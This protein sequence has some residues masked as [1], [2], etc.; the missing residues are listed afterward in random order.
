MQQTTITELRARRIWDSRGRPTIEAQ[1]QLADGSLGLGQAP[2]GASTGRHEALELRDG[3]DDPFL[4]GLDVQTAIRQCDALI[5]PMLIG[6][7][8]DQQ[9]QIDQ[10]LIDIDPHPNKAKLGANTTLAVSL[11]CAKAA[12]QSKAVALYEHLA[13]QLPAAQSEQA[14]KAGWRLPLPQIQIFG[15]G[16]HAAKRID[17]QDLMVTCPAA[18]TVGEALTW[19]A[20]VYRAA[21]EVMRKRRASYG[22]ADEGG[23]WPDFKRNEDALDC[24]MESIELAGLK[25]GE[26]VWFA[27]DIAA[28][29]LFSKG[30]YQLA[31]EQRALSAQDMIAMFAGWHARYPIASIEDPLAEDDSEGFIAITKALGHKL[32]I[33]G[34]DFLVTS[35]Q[36]IREAARQGAANAVLL[37]PNQRGTLSET[38]QAWQIAQDVGYQG[39]VSA[40]S[41]ETEDH[42]IVHLA[43]AWGVPQL[44]VGSFSRGERMVKWNELLRLEDQLGD[45]AFFAGAAALQRIR[46]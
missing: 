25:P 28:S 37:K 38:C 6:Q 16:A 5:R 33:V 18:S 22:V 34:D 35:A 15:G 26:E 31:L 42:S 23:W 2:A 19:T 43:I 8:A 12:A 36:R 24:L 3:D 44:K 14:F 30:A 7:Q 46:S 45:R 40:R 27:L 4:G 11:A 41:G 29:Q 39:I 21:G 20:R 32:Q 10:C 1:V 13:A 9:S 17:V